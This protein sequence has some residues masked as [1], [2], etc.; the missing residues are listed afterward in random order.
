MERSPTKKILF[1]PGYY[2]NHG[3]EICR[4]YKWGQPE[5]T[6]RKKCGNIIETERLPQSRKPEKIYE[7]AE[8]LLKNGKR[9]ELFGRRE[10]MRSNW[11]TVGRD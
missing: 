4:L 1:S 8:K 9:L 7:I 10:N 3:C 2:L 5:V 6:F 11:I